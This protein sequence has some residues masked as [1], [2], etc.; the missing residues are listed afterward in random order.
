MA[1]KIKDFLSKRT[2]GELTL[3]AFFVGVMLLAA[4]VKVGGAVGA[5]G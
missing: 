1:N 5:L 2:T 3:I 4:G